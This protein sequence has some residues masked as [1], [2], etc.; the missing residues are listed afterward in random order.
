MSRYT[1][2]GATLALAGFMANEQHRI[3]DANQYTRN[4]HPQ[5]AIECSMCRVY[6]KNALR[7]YLEREWPRVALP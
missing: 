3:D 2:A 7:V 4:A 5:S 6:I 1:R